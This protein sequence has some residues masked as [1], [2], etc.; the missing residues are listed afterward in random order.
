MSIVAV[1]ASCLK[2]RCH[3]HRKRLTISGGVMTWDLA[4]ISALENKC[5]VDTETF[6]TEIA[7]HLDVILR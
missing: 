6:L 4:A 1:M 5:A 3:S 2:K 7:G